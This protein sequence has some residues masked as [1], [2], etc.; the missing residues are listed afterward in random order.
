MTMWKG[1]RYYILTFIILLPLAPF[2]LLQVEPGSGIMP[3]WYC[4]LGD[5]I[6]G[7]KQ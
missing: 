5:K 7:I 3:E 1:F 2:A 6:A 4:K